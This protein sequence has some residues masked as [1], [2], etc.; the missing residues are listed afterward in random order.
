MKPNNTEYTVVGLNVSL[1]EQPVGVS[2]CLL[3]LMDLEFSGGE[4]ESTRWLLKR[5]KEIKSLER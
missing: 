3:M 5:I 2:V 4:S 1:T